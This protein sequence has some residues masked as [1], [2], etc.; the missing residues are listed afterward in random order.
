[1]DESLGVNKTGIAHNLGRFFNLDLSA[2]FKH[3][4]THIFDSFTSI[5]FQFDERLDNIVLKF[6]DE[7]LC[8]VAHRV[9][10]VHIGKQVNSNILFARCR[11][12]SIEIPR[13]LL[14][15]VLDLLIEEEGVS[16]GHQDTAVF[17]VIS[18]R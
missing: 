13:P 5:L 16:H 18:I 2:I 11:D 4:A 10:V 17:L 6:A 15:E 7:L 1:M 14:T 12:D 9:D 3:L 8:G